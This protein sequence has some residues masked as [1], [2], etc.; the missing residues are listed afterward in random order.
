MGM[1]KIGVASLVTGL[2]ISRMNRWIKL[3]FSML[4]HIQES[5]DVLQ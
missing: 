3:R 1:V 5:Y 2:C 4:K